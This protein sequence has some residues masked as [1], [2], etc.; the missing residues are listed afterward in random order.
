MTGI[1]IVGAGFMG[2]TWAQ[3]THKYTEDA[4]VVA[5]AGGRRAPALAADF[6]CPVEES[7]LALIKRSD[8]DAVVI[9]TPASSHLGLIRDAAAHGKHVL[10]EKPMA[11]SVRDAVEMESMCRESGVT[12]AV[13][14]QHRFRDSPRATKKLLGDGALGDV[15][16]IQ[17]FG[18]EVGWNLP[19]SWWSD[20]PHPP[21]PYS[22]WGTHACDVIR[23]FV[24][25]EPTQAYARFTSFA[26]KP[27]PGQTAMVTYDFRR[28]A[29]AHV[30]MSYDV[31]VPGLGSALQFLIVGSK[32]VL[33]LDSYGSVRIARGGDWELVYEQTPFD[34]YDPMDEV[35]LRAYTREMADFLAASKEKRHPLV[36]GQE[37]VATMQMIEAAE[38]SAAS[39]LP[40]RIPVS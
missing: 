39:G 7:P 31:P 21:S 18:P 29:L 36:S 9:A 3:V 5:V 20:D 14:S 16:M 1:G 27:P 25:D 40:V 22:D 24:Q 38:R 13:V 23:W 37:G 6:G 28:G 26:V 8:V 32:A 10:V 19:D 33:R 15:R 12:L 4:H 34:P 30:W 35:R 17:A 11:L 2:R